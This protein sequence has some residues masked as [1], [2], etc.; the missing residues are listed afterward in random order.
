[1]LAPRC[2]S[3]IVAS[4]EQE[5]VFQRWKSYCENMWAKAAEK[6][7]KFLLVLNFF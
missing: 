5:L 1:V 4:P 2:S 7:K 6:K 3:V